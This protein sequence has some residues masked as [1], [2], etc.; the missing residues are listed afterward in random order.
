VDLLALA[1]QRVA[2][3]RVGVLA[4]DQRADAA[5]AR[6]GHAQACTIAGRPDELLVERGHELAVLHEQLPL[7]ADEQV[8]VPD[9][10]HTGRAAFAHADGDEDAAAPRLGG[11]ALHLGAIGVDAVFH[12]RS[13]QV[14]VVD[15]RPQRSPYRKRRDERLR[16]RYQRRTMRGRLADQRQRLVGGGAPIEKHWCRVRGGHLHNC[17]LCHQRNPPR[18]CV[19]AVAAK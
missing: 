17:P 11:D 18:A 8:R 15:R 3:Q 2:G 12:H 10:A 4:A 14:M 9:A 7:V 16:K 19:C 6:V 1:H 13:E 5:D